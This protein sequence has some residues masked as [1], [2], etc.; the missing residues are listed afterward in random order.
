MRW[1]N[2]RGLNKHTFRPLTVNIVRNRAVLVLPLTIRF[3]EQESPNR[4]SQ[5][6]RCSNSLPPSGT[7]WHLPQGSRGKRDGQRQPP[8]SQTSLD[9]LAYNLQ[10][11]EKG[12]RTGCHDGG[13]HVG[14]CY[15]SVVGFPFF[16]QD[17]SLC[18]FALF[19]CSKKPGASRD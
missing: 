10:L 8:P 9:G 4:G 7:R 5:G 6:K 1:R 15:H 18:C 17:C 19:S 14:T 13:P 16:Y 2:A 3:H 11:K 12:R